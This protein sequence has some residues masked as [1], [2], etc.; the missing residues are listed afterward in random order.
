MSAEE[1]MRDHWWWR[2]G[3]RPGR[4][5][6][7]GGILT[8][9]VMAP[10][11]ATRAFGGDVRFDQFVHQGVCRGDIQAGQRGGLIDRH[12]RRGVDGQQGEQARGV[13]GQRGIGP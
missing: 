7:L 5:K 10:D 8:Q 12:A 4:R 11:P 6:K 2:A 3:W 1:T 9:Q 13:G